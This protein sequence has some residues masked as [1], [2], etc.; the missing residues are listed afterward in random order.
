[1]P[2]NT[3]ARTRLFLT[4]FKYA[5]LILPPVQTYRFVESTRMAL[6]EHYKCEQQQQQQKVCVKNSPVFTVR[7]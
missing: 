3:A 5:L 7:K 4:Q 1:M 2:E 6:F